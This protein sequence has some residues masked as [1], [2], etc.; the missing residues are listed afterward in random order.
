M[1]GRPQPSA[2]IRWISDSSS[3][4]IMFAPGPGNGKLLG[5]AVMG[6]G[7]IEVD[8]RNGQHPSNRSVL[9]RRRRRA[10]SGRRCPVLATNA[11]GEVA[12][13]GRSAFVHEQILRAVFPL[14]IDGAIATGSARSMIA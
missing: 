13:T 8:G 14:S 5:V 3:A 9:S 1:L 12:V 11:I 4:T 10:P 7:V 6:G 2:D